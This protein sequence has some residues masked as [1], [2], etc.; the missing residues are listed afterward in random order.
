MPR[1]AA[2][3]QEPHVDTH[4]RT[5]LGI[6]LGVVAGATLLY[7]RRATRYSCRF[8]DQVWR[9]FAALKPE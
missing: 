4:D 3:R 9:D 1:I 5:R 8:A 6:A 2:A 7:G